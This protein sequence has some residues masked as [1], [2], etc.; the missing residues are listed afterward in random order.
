LQALLLEQQRPYSFSIA[1]EAFGEDNAY[2]RD[3]AQHLRTVHEALTFNAADF[4]TYIERGISVTGKPY[5]YQGEAM[6]LKLYEHIAMRLPE[7]TVVSGQTADG[8]LDSNIP[9]PIQIA[10]G[11]R[12][13]P[14]FLLD[15]AL[16]Y[17][18]DEWRGLASHLSGTEISSELLRRIERRT[19]ICQRVARYLGH[20]H[21][22]Y[23]LIASTAN[24]FSGNVEDKLA[25]SHLYNGAMRRMPN[26]WHSLADSVDL[27]L[28]FPFLE[29]RFLEYT[30]TIPA[31]L[32]RRKYLGK[33]L[34]ERHIPRT[35]V[36][37]PKISKRVPYGKLYTQQ[38][39]WVDLLNTIK[40]SNYYGFNVDEMINQKEYLLLLRL[41]NFHLWKR[42]IIDSP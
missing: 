39:E 10:L 36:H 20:S 16:A 6:F 41:I 26:M 22:V 28:T 29:P 23:S 2:A 8:A 4:L 32:K 33:K 35:Y 19:H 17:A 42:D 15:N 31:T 9:R 12:C 34:A 3:V 18:S 40:K 25:K 14:S 37:R 7:A 1:F 11:L 30:L 21:D 5:M 27:K 24:S 13:L 38:Q